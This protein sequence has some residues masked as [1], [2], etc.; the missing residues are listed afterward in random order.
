MSQSLKALMS[1]TDMKI[2]VSC[3]DFDIF[4]QSIF[5]R[6]HKS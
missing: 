1:I 2:D 4:S 5:F 3:S 6:I